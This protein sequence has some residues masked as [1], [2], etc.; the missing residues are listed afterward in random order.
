M[1]FDAAYYQRYYHNSETRAVSPEEQQRQARFV[2]AYLR[3]LDVEVASIVDIGCGIGTLLQAF[4]REFP[5]ASHH[6]IEFSSYLCD[7]YGWQQGSVVDIATDP[8]DLVI[9]NDVLAYLDNK[10]CKKAINHL[11]S[12][13]QTALYL[14]VMTSEDKDIVDT[15]HSDMQQQA[16]SH[17]WYRKHLDPHFQSV[18]GGLF[19]KKPLAVSLWR[20]EY[21]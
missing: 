9:C 10:S 8:A 12:L 17:R 2:A 15:Q 13:T 18:G 14:S 4:Q 7:T 21:S 6:G 19:I 11:A 3:Y 20:L 1:T 5:E 16:R